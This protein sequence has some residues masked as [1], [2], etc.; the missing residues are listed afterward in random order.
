MK[1]IKLVGL[2]GIAQSAQS[3]FLTGDQV[4]VSPDYRDS[5]KRSTRSGAPAETQWPSG[6]QYG[7]MSAKNDQPM[8]WQQ[9]NHLRHSDARHPPIRSVGLTAL[10][11]VPTDDID[12]VSPNSALS[13]QKTL[14]GRVLDAQDIAHAKNETQNIKLVLDEASHTVRAN[15]HYEKGDVLKVINQCRKVVGKIEKVLNDVIRSGDF[16]SAEKRI[17]KVLQNYVQ[18]TGLDILSGRYYLRDQPLS[19]I[20][21]DMLYGDR[22]IVEFAA[23]TKRLGPKPCLTRQKMNAQRYGEIYGFLALKQMMRFT[24]TLFAPGGSWRDSCTLDSWDGQNLM[25]NC[26]DSQGAQIQTAI[27]TQADESLM[28]DEGYLKLEY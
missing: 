16:C 3:A 12:S 1:S 7:F 20:S 6:G 19:A 26:T 22:L 13:A 28:N 24:Q 18:K 8:R 5:A 14:G 9:L 27:K 10:H 15:R 4:G 17:Q 2:L 21:D 23:T 11:S 25:A